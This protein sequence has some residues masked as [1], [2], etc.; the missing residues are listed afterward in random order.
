M[1]S[2]ANRSSLFESPLVPRSSQQ[3][4]AALQGVKLLY[5]QRQYK[6][7][8]ARA[9]ELLEKSR[10]PLHPVYKTYLYFYSA[11]CYEEMGRA[12]HKY[13]S[14]KIPLLQGA[15]DRF[16]ICSTVL[17]SPIPALS[18]PSEESNF[19]SLGEIS[20]PSE[21]SDSPS[22]ICS[23]VS[24]ITDI[25]DKTIQWK[26]EDPF[27]SDSDSCSDTDIGTMATAA[28][29][30]ANHLLVPPPLTLRKSSDEILPLEPVLRESGYTAFRG[31]RSD[32]ARLPPPLP[33]KIVPCAV[34]GK[35][36]RTVDSPLNNRDSRLCT[37]DLLINLSERKIV[38]A[39]PQYS[40]S[41]RR[42]NSSL[43]SLRAQIDSSIN[44][45]HVLIDELEEKQHTR[46]MA[47]TIKRSASFWS[48]S[49]VQGGD[50]CWEKVDG[51]K[52]SPGKETKQERIDRLRAEGW[53]TVGLRSAA[54][55]WKGGEYYKDYCSSV[56]DELYL[57]S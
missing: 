45:I 14:T 15:L 7:C 48:F 31:E 21:C 28:Y 55:G 10:E 19:P 44:S 5:V 22:T 40:D 34:T 3:W 12:A 13:S 36:K 50:G 8:A 9:T 29:D 56:L 38:P 1:A 51:P 23:L 24:S 43:R 2:I 4:K 47:K 57:E 53:K 6:Q 16:D 26:E 33:I 46:K 17:P 42:Y 30:R 41:I 18:R 54:R 32:R 25:I 11:V 39:T 52:R 35:H 20:S 49:P 37:D 27:I